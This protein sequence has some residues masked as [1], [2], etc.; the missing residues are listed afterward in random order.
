MLPITED[1][2]A[3]TVQFDEMDTEGRDDGGSHDA[4]SGVFTHTDACRDKRAL[5]N[6][7]STPH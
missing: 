3:A 5:C 2:V 7:L 4:C 6:M 1:T